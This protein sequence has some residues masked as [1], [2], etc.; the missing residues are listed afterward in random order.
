MPPSHWSRAPAGSGSSCRV[1]S[2]KVSS[3]TVHPREAAQRAD[4]V[5]PPQ[6]DGVGHD[7]AALVHVRVRRDAEADE[8]RP[9]AVEL[10]EDELPGGLVLERR[11]AA[12]DERVVLRGVRVRAA[13]AEVVEP[14][15]ADA[16]PEAPRPPPRARSARACS[17]PPRGGSYS[18][19]RMASGSLS[20][21]AGSTRAPRQR[22]PKWRCGPVARPVLPTAPT[23]SPRRT[24]LALGH[25]HA[26][27]VHVHRDERVPVVDEDGVAAE[28]LVG[29]HRHRPVG[30]GEDGRAPRPR[31]SRRPRAGC[32]GCR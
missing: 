17:P 25:V 2:R 3:R 19:A 21:S 18:M 32:G 12:V 14:V 22:T 28:E 7:P 20:R 13:H 29:H 24:C 1:G 15:E 8:A 11:V 23:R 30:G 6:V 26:A 9:Q 31:S 4:E 27:H 10:A 16:G 5:E